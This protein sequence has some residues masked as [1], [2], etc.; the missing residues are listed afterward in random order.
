MG[1]FS[2]SDLELGRTWSV[3]VEEPVR[4]QVSVGD[5]GFMLRFSKAVQSVE[6]STVVET[7]SQPDVVA[8]SHVCLLS[9]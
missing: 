1:C 5:L 4:T 6:N 8:A 9:A 2:I 7:C 3:A